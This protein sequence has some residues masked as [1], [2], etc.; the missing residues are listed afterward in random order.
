MNV[1][2]TLIDNHNMLYILLCTIVNNCELEE[3]GN[4]PNKSI[5]RFFSDILERN[6][7]YSDTL[8]FRRG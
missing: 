3:T 2:V 7:D 4:A 1:D 5:V 8:D 6:N